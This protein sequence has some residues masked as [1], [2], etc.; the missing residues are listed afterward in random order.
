MG[1][2]WRE[3]L[4][5]EE[6]LQTR[7]LCKTD[8]FELG[9]ILGKDFHDQ[10]HKNWRNFYPII[11]PSGLKP[12]Y[13]QE[14][15][16]AWWAS[17]SPIKDR[18]LLASRNAYKSSFNI[19]WAVCA[20]INCADLRLL[21]CSETTK[22]SKGFIRAFRN[23]FETNERNPTRFQQLFAEH[24]IPA[25]DGSSLNFESP[26]R[27]LNLIQFTAEATSFESSV[28][29]QRAD[30]IVF[31]DPISDKSTGT[32]EMCEKGVLTFAAIQ[33]LRE[34][35]GYSLIAG[36]PWRAELDLYAV[37]IRNTTNDSVSDENEKMQIRIDPA[38][39]VRSHARGKHILHLVEDDV[40]LLFP[41]RLTWKFLQKELR[42][43][44]G[45]TSFFRMQNLCEFVSDDDQ[46][47]VTFTLEQLQAAVRHSPPEGQ[48]LLRVCSLD[49][50]FSA[51]RTADFSCLVTADLIR[52]RSREEKDLIFVHDVKLE[53]LKT[54][55]LG[56]LVAETLN[57]LKPD[58]VIAERTGDWVSLQDAIRRAAVIR[59][60]I[61]PDIFWKP[62]SNVAGAALSVKAARAKGMEPMIAD[63][64]LLFSSGIPT[65]ENCFAQMCHF[66][67]IKRSGSSPGSKDDFVD[68]MS[69][70]VQTWGPRTIIE[71]KSE[72]QEEYEASMERQRLIQM[73]HAAI[74]GTPQSPQQ[75]VYVTPSENS[76]DDNKLFGMLSRYGFTRRGT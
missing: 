46:I 49:S 10:P 20:T 36:T 53:R 12:G 8:A 37:L 21:F 16:K 68:S 27:T 47:K 4:T 56:T 30:V 39:T 65:L 31:D 40:D 55:E 48:R 57:R 52:Q 28:A 14:Q 38:W 54:S 32:D 73:Q 6:Y 72:A 19:V 45:N 35:G 18:M 71:P 23:Y 59:G 44:A 17:Q 67:G 50:A 70:L 69:L 76:S 74:F 25:G 64:R 11:D 60:Y 42:S 66:D 1:I 43:G 9:L 15:V 29:G 61:L 62:V 26:M 75:Q 7:N 22:L 58:R 24:T 3:K 2:S 5:F 33:K 41:S 63:G 34:V 13:T 51:A